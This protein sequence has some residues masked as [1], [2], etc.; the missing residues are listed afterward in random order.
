MFDILAASYMSATRMEHFLEQ[1]FMHKDPRVAQ[2]LR[3]RHRMGRDFE[4]RRRYRRARPVIR[5]ALRRAGRL[6]LAGLVRAGHGL[7][8]TGEALETLASRSL[9]RE[10]HPNRFCADGHC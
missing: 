5:P 9:Q 1:D 4:E 6:M 10:V 8:R 7:R 2:R 3:E